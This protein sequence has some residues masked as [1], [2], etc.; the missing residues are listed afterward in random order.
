MARRNLGEHTARDDV[1]RRELGKGVARQHEALALVVDQGSAFAAQRL[2][3][4][5]CGIAA[6][7]DR[8]R[9]ELHE[10]GIGDHGAGAGGDRQSEAARLG[11]IGRHRVEMTDA[12]GGEHYRTGGYDHGFCGGIT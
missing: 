7:H 12:P 5:R 10:F 9:M 3:G 1:A 6:N 8:G 2:G 4:Q 11:R